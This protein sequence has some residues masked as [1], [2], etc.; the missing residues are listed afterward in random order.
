M[1]L[2]KVIRIITGYAFTYSYLHKIGLKNSPICD[3]GFPIQNINHII[4]ACP[5]FQTQRVSF[6][7]TLMNN[8][9][10]PPYSIHSLIARLDENSAKALSKFLNS[11]NLKL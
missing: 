5:N 11:S 10:F 8:N 1:D 3:C 2:V 4:W 6:I 7:A 9:L